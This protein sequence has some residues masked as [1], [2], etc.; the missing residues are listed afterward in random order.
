YGLVAIAVVALPLGTH[1]TALLIISSVVIGGFTPGIVPL[2]LGRVHELVPGDPAL[3]RAIWGRAVTCFAGGQAVGAYGLSALLA[4]GI[5]GYA[6]LFMLAA[7]AAVLALLL[8]L[9]TGL[10]VRGVPEKRLP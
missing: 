6:T 9:A 4:R 7:A 1:L 5:V 8:N 2:A 10:T 3:Q